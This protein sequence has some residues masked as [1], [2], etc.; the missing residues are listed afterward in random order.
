MIKLLTPFGSDRPILSFRNVRCL[1]YVIVNKFE[2][3]MNERDSH[4]FSDAA[5]SSYRR[6]IW[7]YTMF[8]KN[9]KQPGGEALAKCYSQGNHELV[10][11]LSK[12]NIL[13]LKEH[14]REAFVVRDT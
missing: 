11:G 9:L 5:N 8:L 13:L 12:D 6:K 3:W 1:M 4:E 10:D 7:K 14:E 2:L